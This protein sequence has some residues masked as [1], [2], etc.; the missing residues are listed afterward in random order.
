MEILDHL[1][2]ISFFEHL[3]PHEFEA[4]AAHFQLVKYIEGDDILKQGE[5]AN[6]FFI[7]EL[8]AVNLRH[9]DTGGHERPVGSKGPGEYF[10][11]KMFTTQE[12]S[13][14]TFESISAASLWV[15]SRKEWDKVLDENPAMIEHMPEL[16]QEFARL[17]RGLD[18]LSPGEVI[19]LMQ[20]RHW[21]ALVLM[22]RLPLA[23]AI[24]F[25]IAFLISSRLG[26]TDQLSWVLPVYLFVMFGCLLWT[27][28]NAL[29]WWNDTYIVTNKRVVRINKVVFFSESRAE[30]AIE[31]IQSQKVERGGPISVLLNIS[32]L[33]ITSASSD[34]M[35]VVFEQVG[36]VVNIQ[37]VI[38]GEQLRV[39]ERNRAV[40]RE[41]LRSQ[42]A[43]EIRH[44][45]FQQPGSPEPA[46]SATVNRPRTA[47]LMPWQAWT[48]RV[49]VTPA[50]PKYKPKP[51]PLGKRLRETW[52]S[53]F[54]TEIRHGKVVT[55]RKD[56]FVLFAQIGW[57]LVIFLVLTALLIGITSVENLNT[58]LNNGVYGALGIV[59]LIAFLGVIWQWLDWRVDLY[60]LTETEIYDIESLPFGLRYH[61]N[62][63]DLNKIQD[64]TYSREGIINTLLDY[65]NVVTRVAGNAE[66]FTFIAVTH[67]RVVADEISERIEVLKVRATERSTR[68][69]TR[70]VVDAIVAYHRLMMAER[71]QEV[72]APAAPPTPETPSEAE[73]EPPS[74]SV[75]TPQ[76]ETDDEFPSE[77]DMR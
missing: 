12:P 8:G 36:D 34:A 59:M 68:E 45:V 76:L 41:R 30:L 49:P 70:Q 77:A 67:P 51:V 13:E 2:T 21:W 15:L 22:I 35:G 39:Q 16:R 71:H 61:E 52:V 33:R 18:W 9:T 47:I 53:L 62:K 26:V 28:W 48:R 43:G 74:L 57:F 38:S 24:I 75:R 42:I 23:V 1:R 6:H 11:I 3:D 73:P 7:V 63:A 27:A 69:N 32:N 31:K 46:K 44:Y 65:G 29:N 56:Y 20:R 5:Q 72:A 17:T 14:Y 50:K 60:R 55:W 66:P 58:F 10:G 25:T 64:V 37:R 19:D 4:L 54:G 40:E